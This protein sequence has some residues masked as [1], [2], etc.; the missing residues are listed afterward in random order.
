MRRGGIGLAVDGIA[1]GY[2]LQSHHDRDNHGAL[3]GEGV[4]LDHILQQQL[5]AV[6]HHF[7]LVNVVAPFHLDLEFLCKAH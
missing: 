1:D 4:V 5:K 3:A 2:R 7:L 6:G